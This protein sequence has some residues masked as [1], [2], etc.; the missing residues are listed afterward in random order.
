MTTP[1][2]FEI[3]ESGG[4]RV[5]TNGKVRV[6]MYLAEGG[7]MFKR[8]AVGVSTAKPAG[9]M[10]VPQL[11]ALS[12]QLLANPAMPP[13]VVAEALRKLADSVAPKTVVTPKAEW[14]VVELDGVRVYVTGEDVIVTRQDMT[15]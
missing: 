15:P 7:K 1:T 12:S 13:E 4:V 11:N 9:E 3:A 2:P 10:A 5:A 6:L 8:R 14:A